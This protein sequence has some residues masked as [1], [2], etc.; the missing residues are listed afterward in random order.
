MKIVIETTRA[1][2]I[3]AQTVD[4]DAGFVVNTAIPEIGTGSQLREECQR[5]LV[6][7]VTNGLGT[8]RKVELLLDFLGEEGDEINKDVWEDKDA[9][10]NCLVGKAFRRY[11]AI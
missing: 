5:D 1:N 10:L 9:L 8:V 4:I 2:G 11:V 7:I 3:M 6:D